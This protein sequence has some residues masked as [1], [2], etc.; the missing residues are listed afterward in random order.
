METLFPVQ[1][2]SLCTKSLGWY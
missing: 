2:P 1:K